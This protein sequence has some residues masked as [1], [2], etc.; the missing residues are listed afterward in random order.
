M[1]TFWLLLILA[2]LFVVGSAGALHYLS[3]P[4]HRKHRDDTPR[5]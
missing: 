2:I 3:R 1:K 5:T 4:G